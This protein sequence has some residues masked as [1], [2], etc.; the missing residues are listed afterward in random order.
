[1][2]AGA[3]IPRLTLTLGDVTGDGSVE[4]WRDPY[5]CAAEARR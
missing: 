1:M 5:L 3:P 4:L 2:D